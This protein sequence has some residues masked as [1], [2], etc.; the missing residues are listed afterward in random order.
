MLIWCSLMGLP[1]P[2]EGVDDF[3]DRTVRGERPDCSLIRADA[4]PALLAL[5]RQAWSADPGARPTA[6]E[7]AF[8]LE[9]MHLALE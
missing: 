6:V 2:W 3:E 1:G 8:A 9:G 5:M 4:Q 7:M